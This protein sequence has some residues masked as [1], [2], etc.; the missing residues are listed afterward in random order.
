MSNL[1]FA[2]AAAAVPLLMATFVVLPLVEQISAA[3]ANLPM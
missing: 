3:L 2:I 1:Y